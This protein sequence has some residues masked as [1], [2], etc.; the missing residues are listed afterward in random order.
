M[1]KLN[2]ESNSDQWAC[3]LDKILVVEKY[4]RFLWSVMT[5][6]RVAEPSR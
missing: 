1:T 4:S 2:W 5:L 6:I 3:L